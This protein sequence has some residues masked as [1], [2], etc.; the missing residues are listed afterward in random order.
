VPDIQEAF[1]RLA[2]AAGRL[3]GTPRGSV[4]TITAAPSFA[5][6][7]LMPRL[8]S[9]H[10]AHPGIE[11]RLDM[12]G[13]L[14]DLARESI[15]LGIRYGAGHYPGLH[16]TL[17]MTEKVFPVCSP[18]LVKAGQLLEPDAL[19]GM[20]LIHDTAAESRPHGPSWSSWLESIGSTID[21]RRGVCVNSGLLALQ[22]AIEG[23]GVALARS[24]LAATDLRQGRLVRPLRGTY[25][26]RQAYYLVYPTAVSLGG[27]AATFCQWLKDAACQFAKE[28]GEP[29]GIAAR[30][31]NAA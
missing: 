18:A 27:A 14:V 13:H 1:D 26:S 8:A 29:D 6:K 5:T 17:L 23:H 30:F 25:V 24:V 16:S 31:A 28:H 11:L 2:R 12:S 7:W 10:S 19:A 20:T 9:F 15:A 4:V 22:M 21:A 3:R